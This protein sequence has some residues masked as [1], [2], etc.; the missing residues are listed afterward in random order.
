MSD[1]D[2]DSDSGSA[3]EAASPRPPA[4]GRGG[5]VDLLRL[6]RLPNLFTAA[7][8]SLAGWLLVSGTWD[9]PDLW[10]PLAFASV[11][12]Y[13]GGIVLNDRAD[14][15]V[16]MVERPGRP[17]P[18]GRVSTRTA[19]ILVVLFLALGL[20]SAAIAGGPWSLPVAALLVLAVLAYDLGGKRTPLGPLLMGSCRGLNFALGMSHDAALGGVWGSLAALGL[21]LFVVGLTWVSRW[22]A[23]SGRRLGLA[24]GVAHQ[25]PAAILLIVVCAALSSAIPGVSAEPLPAA[26]VVRLASLH[27]VPAGIVLAMVLAFVARDNLRAWRK[28]I[29]PRMQAAVKTAVFSLVWLD[30]ALAAAARGVHL[31]APLVLLWLAAFVVGKRLYST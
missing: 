30:F 10:L 2:S 6:V 27:W 23:E 8:D 18:S 13:A 14:L 7:A 16:D 17:L 31:A 1:S 29:P 15:R 4:R 19:E 25:A 5:P 11:T 3:S 24:L 21:A 12:I 22:E 9:R 20:A 28:P 26:S